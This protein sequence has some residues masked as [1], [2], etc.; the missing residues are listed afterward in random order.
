VLGSVC[1]VKRY[2]KEVNGIGEH[3]YQALTPDICETWA[4]Y[5]TTASLSFLMSNI[6]G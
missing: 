4:N 6:R 3:K 2:V 1:K 5:L